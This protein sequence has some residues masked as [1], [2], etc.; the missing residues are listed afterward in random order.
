MQKDFHAFQRVLD[1]EDNQTGGGA[2]S[3]IASA[4]GAALVGMVARLSIGRRDME[5]DAFYQRIDQ[6]AQSLSQRLIDGAEA[7]AAA[8]D[9]VMS[10]Y[11]RPKD[12]EEQKVERS[13]A[14]QKAMVQATETPMANAGWSV[15]TLDLCDQLKD[16]SNTNAASDL[17]CAHHL[18]LAGLRGALSNVSINLSAIKDAEERE[19]LES[20]YHSLLARADSFE[21]SE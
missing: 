13:A 7:D 9:A 19:R 17:A 12:T 2:A 5:P 6:Q 14:I 10:A 18:A 21:G 16:R 8:F 1:P 11:R 4:M 20:A 3:A 15:Q